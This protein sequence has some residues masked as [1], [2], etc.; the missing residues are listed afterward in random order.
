MND[1]LVE[2]QKLARYFLS[3]LSSS[4]EYKKWVKLYT[5]GNSQSF[6]DQKIEHSSGS[7]YTTK[8]KRQNV[9]DHTQDFIVNDVRRAL[10][11]AISSFDG[12]LQNEKD[13]E[14]LIEMQF[15]SLREAF[16]LCADNDAQNKVCAKLLNLY[17]TGRLGHYTLDPPALQKE[18]SGCV[19]DRQMLV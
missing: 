11:L 15:T 14:K 8:Q 16:R 9:T 2:K 12:N 4:D 3:I 18:F 1:C 5:Y 6:M 10:S 13:L 19:Q 17:R 7:E